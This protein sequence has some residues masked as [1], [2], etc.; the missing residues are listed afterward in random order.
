MRWG[1]LSPWCSHHFWWTRFIRRQFQMD[2]FGL[3][4]YVEWLPAHRGHQKRRRREGKRH[5]FLFFHGCTWKSRETWQGT[6]PQTCS[7]FPW[8]R[9]PRT[10]LFW[11]AWFPHCIMNI[12]PPRP[13]F[14]S[15]LM[16]LFHD[17]PSPYLS[18]DLS[19]RIS[20]HHHH[21]AQDPNLPWRLYQRHNR[22][23]EGRWLVF[24]IFLIASEKGRIVVLIE[25]IINL[26]FSIVTPECLLCTRQGLFQ[27]YFI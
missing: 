27:L 11:D 24:W 9:A 6:H 8:P 12:P 7:V 1:T 19:L 4:V 23:G 14:R 13:P 10:Y 26:R 16:L 15:L 17:K 22:G 2:S 25:G 20:V 18:M 21:L 3:S 5:Y